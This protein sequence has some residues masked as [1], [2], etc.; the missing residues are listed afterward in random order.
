MR[1]VLAA[2]LVAISVGVLVSSPVGVWALALTFLAGS[3]AA[4]SR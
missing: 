2:A 4:P 1:F 3:L